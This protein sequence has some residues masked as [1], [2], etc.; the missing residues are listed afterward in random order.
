MATAKSAAL[1][2]PASPMANVATGMPPGICTMASRESNPCKC[3]D[4]I[5]TA[6]TGKAVTVGDNTYVLF[7][8]TPD[9]FSLRTDLGATAFRFETGFATLED[10]AGRSAAQITGGSLAVN[11]SAR[12]FAT[13][14]GL[15]HPATG[16]VTLSRSGRLTDDGMFA[17]RDAQGVVAG[18]VSTDG[19]QVGY[20][21]QQLTPQG[22]LSGLTQWRR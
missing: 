9:R 22:T 11:F 16:S 20:L 14:L 19:S 8:E 17:A 7:R 6:S 5:G 2:A 15:M 12:E 1:T 4:G 13:T 10:T 3:L 21:F 18:A